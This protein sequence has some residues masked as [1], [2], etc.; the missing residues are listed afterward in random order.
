[1]YTGVL[2]SSGGI[3]LSYFSD[4]GY[5]SER[6]SFSEVRGKLAG[7]FTSRLVKFLLE[8]IVITTVGTNQFILVVICYTSRI[9]D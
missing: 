5:G 9:W 4:I 3:R 8:I 6:F 2:S 7:L 1:M